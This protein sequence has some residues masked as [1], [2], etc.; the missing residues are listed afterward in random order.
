MVSAIFYTGF[1]TKKIDFSVSVSV[2][3]CSF[4]SILLS[5]I[6]FWF[7]SKIKS[8]FRIC[9]SM[10]SGVF[11]V[12][13]RK[14]SASSTSTACMSS[15]ILLAIFSFHRN[16]FRFCGFQLN[17]NNYFSMIRVLFYRDSYL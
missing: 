11:P 17:C 2:A 14:K 6:G 12:S 1:C 7:A 5:V 9:Y 3:I 8:G 15:L 4:C 13:L 10:R 16:L